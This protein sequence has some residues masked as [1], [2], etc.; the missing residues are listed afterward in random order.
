M[1]QNFQSLE[2]GSKSDPS[3]NEHNNG[4]KSLSEKLEEALAIINAKEQLV[5]QHAKVAEEAVSGI[6]KSTATKIQI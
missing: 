6:V 3:E 4:V 1:N 2:V 5:N